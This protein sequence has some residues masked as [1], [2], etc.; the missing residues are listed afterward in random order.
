[1]LSDKNLFISFSFKRGGAAKAAARFYLISE[2][3]FQTRKI[4]VEES[5]KN[6]YKRFHFLK[7]VFSFVFVF[8]HQKK[9]GVKCSANFFSFYPVV[10]C[11]KDK[12]KLH[13]IHWINND[14]VS[15]FDFNKIPCA[16]IITLHDEWLY[17]GVE[18][19]LDVNKDFERSAYFLDNKINSKK[20][21]GFIH[22][23]VWNVKRKA[24]IGRNDL[25]IT[26]PSE[27]LANR[28]RNS[29]V[30]K[31]CDV[32]VLY[33]PVDVSIF[34]PLPRND[35]SEKRNQLELG[36]RFLVIFGAV[37]GTKNQL[38]GFS[39]LEAALELLAKNDVMKDRIALGLFG[40][41]KKGVEQLHGF[42]VYEFGYI[43]S[44]QEMAEIYSLAHVT[45]VPS[46]LESFGQ[47]AAESQSCETPTI[48]F[49]TSGLKDVVIDGKTGFL[50]EPFSPTSLAEKIE[51]MV[52]LDSNQYEQL[53]KSARLHVIEKFSSEVVA[54]QYKSI[55]NEQ[56]MKKQE[57][58]K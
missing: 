29:H 9:Y 8:F 27:W 6:I 57:A 41:E 15:I 14:T 31:D 19:Y 39:E 18:H 28:A 51:L 48:A 36:D 4:S 22:K 52:S 11:F 20:H 23:F 33:N 49:E 24:L 56:L 43:P 5:S 42:P 44:E 40:G 21:I 35:L 37:G 58:C 32:R 16:S 3:F 2:Y 38:K 53:C 45:V 13:H 47:V 50:A 54:K 26:C 46:K 10:Q 25:V 1:M 7:R 12:N 17:C 55:I 34:S 30:L